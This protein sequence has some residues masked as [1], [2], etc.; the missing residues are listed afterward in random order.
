MSPFFEF[1]K[2]ARHFRQVQLDK[3]DIR[4]REATLEWCPKQEKFYWK[5]K[6]KRKAKKAHDQNWNG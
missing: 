5:P 1:E 6:K 4:Y 2:E 3:R